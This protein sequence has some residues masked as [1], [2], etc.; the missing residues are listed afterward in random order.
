MPNSLLSPT[1]CVGIGASSTSSVFG[2]ATEDH[3]RLQ[4]MEMAASS[5]AAWLLRS[6]SAYV[7]DHGLS[8]DLSRGLKHAASLIDNVAGASTCVDALHVTARLLPVCE[9]HISED[10]EYVPVKS[11]VIVVEKRVREI[12]V[13]RVQST[14]PF[15]D[16]KA[17]GEAVDHAFGCQI[18][19]GSH[20]LYSM[21][22]QA[23]KKTIWGNFEAAFKSKCE[24]EKEQRGK[25]RKG[26]PKK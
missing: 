2:M 8:P 20:N 15:G 10:L 18:A 25:K 16:P 26:K 12:L 1:S 5:N 7:L 6:A 14:L 23:Y 4:D 24:E 11:L 22:M 19:R 13:M 3:A 17:F 9:G 21:V